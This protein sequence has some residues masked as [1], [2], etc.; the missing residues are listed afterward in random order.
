MATQTVTEYIELCD[1]VAIHATACSPPQALGP[2]GGTV[3]AR[4][5]AY[6]LSYA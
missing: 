1:E 4:F 3:R 5:C 6:V 2:V